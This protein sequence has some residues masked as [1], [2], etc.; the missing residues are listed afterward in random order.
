VTK[1]KGGGKLKKE[2]V[3]SHVDRVINHP[4]V[5]ADTKHFI[6]KNVGH[7]IKNR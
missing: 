3:A 1:K 7:N 6:P 5:T 4:M 2:K